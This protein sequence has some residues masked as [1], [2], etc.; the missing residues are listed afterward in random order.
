MR[1]VVARGKKTSD[2]RSEEKI[3]MVNGLVAGL[4]ILF[5]NRYIV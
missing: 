3:D 1:L 4:L 5:K 2:R